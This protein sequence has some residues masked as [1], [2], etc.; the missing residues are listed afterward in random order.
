MLK[1]M[2]K[3]MERVNMSKMLIDIET[4]NIWVLFNDIC[5]M[6]ENN[7]LVKEFSFEIIKNE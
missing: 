5:S 3:E 7:T 2:I 1:N 4:D 6:L